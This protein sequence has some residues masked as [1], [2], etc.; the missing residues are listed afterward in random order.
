MPAVVEY[1]SRVIIL[2][3]ASG[4]V[5][6]FTTQDTKDGTDQLHIVKNEP[7]EEFPNDLGPQGYRHNG[8]DGHLHP[9][10]GRFTHKVFYYKRYPYVS[11]VTLRTSHY[12]NFMACIE[13]GTL[14]MFHT[15]KYHGGQR[16]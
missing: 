8:P 13:F 4:S 9:N 16:F 11:D 3:I 5:T 15:A 2:C 1:R 7:F 14:W 6:L 10:R 12:C